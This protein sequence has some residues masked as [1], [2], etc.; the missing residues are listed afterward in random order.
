MDKI[1]ISKKEFDELYELIP[2]IE[3][4]VPG[5]K[6][7]LVEKNV[8]LSFDDYTEEMDKVTEEVEV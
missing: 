8:D 1:K 3:E 6:E 2:D 7:V 4:K 5:S